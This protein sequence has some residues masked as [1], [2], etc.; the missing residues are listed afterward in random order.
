MVI[1]DE[2][3]AYLRSWQERNKER[4]A[5]YRNATKDLRNARRREIYAQ[6]EEHRKEAI[7]AAS[8][9]RE[10]YPMRR[11]VRKYGLT[12][13]DLELM[14]NN[15]CAICGANPLFCDQVKMHIDHDHRSGKVRGVLCQPCNLALGHI[16]DDPNIAQ[17]M[18]DYL[19]E[20]GS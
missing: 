3:L 9:Y 13:T 4:V 8:A 6:S 2:K 15:G 19:L 18:V 5:S 11:R 10:K 12:E 20:H 1:S 16:Y 14:S 17:R 7:A